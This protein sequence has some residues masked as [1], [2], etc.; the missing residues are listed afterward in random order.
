MVEKSMTDELRLWFLILYVLGIV[1]L[2]I[3]F[4]L[5]RSREKAVEKR[6]AD[7]RC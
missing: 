2:F 3:K 4:I 6:I 5:A 7:R 1:A